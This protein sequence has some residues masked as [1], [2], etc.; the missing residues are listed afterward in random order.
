MKISG[1]TFLRNGSLLG[2]P[3]IESLKS[4]L[5]VA[6]E[7]IVAVG[8][9]VDDTLEQVRAIGDPR[10]RIIETVWNESMQD[11]GYVY[12]QQKMSA[13]FSCTGDWAFYLEGDE[14]IHED[15]APKIRAALERHLNNPKVEA[16]AFDYHH[17]YGAPSKV[18]RSPAWYRKAVRVIRN[19]VRNYSPDGLFFVVMEH[20]KI[21]RYPRAAL[22]GVPIYHYGHV[23]KSAAM[24]EKINQVSRYWKHTPKQHNYG[25][26][27]PQTVVPFD[28]SHPQVVQ[29]WLAE[30]AEPHFEPDPDHTLTRRERKHRWVMKAERLLGGADFTR[31]H[32]TLVRD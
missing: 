22:A 17:F 10:I 5:Q 23:R 8:E 14:V 28:G 19:S 18:A 6:D 27:D 31:K 7:V 30:N 32:Y 13:Q 4:L 1:F 24:Q 3:Y 16:L 26:I 9:S 12:A 11:R 2:Y 20:N 15:D 21:G 29:A 25:A